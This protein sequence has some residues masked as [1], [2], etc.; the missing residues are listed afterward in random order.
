MPS[1]VRTNTVLRTLLGCA[2]GLA[3]GAGLGGA[4]VLRSLWKQLPSVDHLAEPMLP[5][6]IN[7]RVPS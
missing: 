2:L 5:M 1:R 6:R 3:L 4:Y 7:A